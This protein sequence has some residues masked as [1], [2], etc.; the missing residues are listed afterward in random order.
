[1]KIKDY[2]II[3]TE[4]IN[5]LILELELKFANTPRTKHS[6][7]SDSL[8]KRIELL[9]EIKSNLKP[10]TT[11]VE[12]SFEEGKEAYIEGT[13]SDSGWLYKDLKEE[14]INNTIIE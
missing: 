14:F 2:S 4:L 10:L 11:I 6:A 3:E 7:K 12:Q 13:F 5:T 9:K 8:L 1:M